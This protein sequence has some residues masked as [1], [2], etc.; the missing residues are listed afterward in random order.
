[1]MR[2]LSEAA[3]AGGSGSP[4]LRFR[5]VCILVTGNAWRGVTVSTLRAQTYEG[6]FQES[7]RFRGQS[8]WRGQ[9]EGGQAGLL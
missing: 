7:G 3:E 1:V 2:R 6:M 9:R 8:M 5:N 4:V